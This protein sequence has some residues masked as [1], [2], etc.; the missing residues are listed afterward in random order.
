M[1]RFSD[2]AGDDRHSFLVLC[3]SWV[4]YVLILYGGPL[5]HFGEGVTV[6]HIHEL[7]STQLKTHWGPSADFQ[8]SLNSPVNSSHI[9]LPSLSAPSSYLRWI[10]FCLGSPPP[11]A[12]AW[13]L[14]PGGKLGQS[15]AYLVCFLS[16]R[17]HW[18]SL[19]SSSILR[20][21]VS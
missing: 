5:L 13:K 4:L 1:M 18:P 2:V 21:I 9:G 7:I 17:G 12:A 8:R 14:S 20:T 3:S 19:T 11:H 6:C 10:S 16:L 15:R